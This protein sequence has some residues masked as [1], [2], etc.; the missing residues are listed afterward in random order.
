MIIRDKHK[1]EEII[2]SEKKAGKSVLVKKGVFDIIH[3]GHIFAINLLRKETDTVVILV[4]SDELTEKQKGSGRPINGQEQRMTVVDA[5][6]GIDYVYPDESRSREEYIDFLKYLKPTMVAVKSG[7]QGKTQAYSSHLW[8]LKE[9]S[10]EDG[11]DFS[12]T[13]IIHRAAGLG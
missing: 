2:Q 9:F 4:Q 1:L 11:P 5:I 8:T 3:P 7:D 13:K 10:E 6:K 12:T